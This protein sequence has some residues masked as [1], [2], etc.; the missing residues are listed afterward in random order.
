MKYLVLGLILLL[1]VGLVVF[2]SLGFAVSGSH[3]LML[4]MR[5][6]MV[7]GIYFAS[8]GA[9][10]GMISLVSAIAAFFKPKSPAS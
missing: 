2:A 5:V 4:K 1:A 7:T 9:M 8:I 10:L 3:D 6:G